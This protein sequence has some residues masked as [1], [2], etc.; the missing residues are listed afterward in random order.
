MVKWTEWDFDNP[1]HR[2]RR[3]PQVEQYLPPEQPRQ[4]HINVRHSHRLAPPDLGMAAVVAFF[5]LVLLSWPLRFGLLLLM[6]MAPRGFLI[7]LAVMVAVVSIVAA[8][9]R[10]R[11]RPF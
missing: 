11:R 5:A 9:Q 10:R 6:A 4:L 3:R 2:Q 7:E 8:I 1:V